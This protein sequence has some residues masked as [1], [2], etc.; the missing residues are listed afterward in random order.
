VKNTLTFRLLD[1]A[2]IHKAGLNENDI[3]PDLRIAYINNKLMKIYRLLDGLNDPWY[4][5]QSLAVTVGSDVIIQGDVAH[6]V[7][8]IDVSAH[9]I[10]RVLAANWKL[11]EVF[12]LTISDATTNVPFVGRVI[13]V[14]SIYKCT[15]E[16]IAGTETAYTDVANQRG[17][18]VRISAPASS[19][20]DIS[21]L[22]VKD[23]LRIWDNAY[24]GGKVRIFTEIKDPQ[25]FSVLHRDPYFN[26]RIAWFH[27]GDTI[28]LFVGSTATA[29]ATVNFEYR[30]KP[31]PCTDFDTDVYVDIPPEDNQVLMDEVFAE[32]LTHMKMPV[33]ED[34]A[35]RQKE[36][37]ARYDAAMQDVQR[38]QALVTG[39]RGG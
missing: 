24:T 1:A 30:G 12:V 9:T 38:K 15:Y 17:T 3:V 27:R 2:L 7:W 26:N 19:T 32:Y 31:T 8:N 29:L 34:I 28:E 6:A 20:I 10:T 13:Q 37:A 36:F 16:V 11:G 25:I 33:P 18:Y 23:I 14:N 39:K 21:S 5:K 22:Y 35:N 4:H